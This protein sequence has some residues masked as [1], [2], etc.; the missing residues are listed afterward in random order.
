LQ[1]LKNFD[2]SGYKPGNFLKRSLWYFF[3]EIFFNTFIPF[4][5]FIK[6]KILKFFGAG[7]GKCVIIKPRVRIKYPWFLEIGDYSWI[8]EDVWI[9]NLDFVVIKENVCVSQ[10]AMILSGAHNYKSEK[11][12]LIT[13]KIIIESGAWICAKSVVLQGVK[14]K[15]N[16]ILSTSS[17]AVSDLDANFIY[18]GNPAIK[19]KER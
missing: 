18:K 7:V 8:G 15:S 10:G 3:S 5:G 12:D 9:D 13:K 16:S 4:P 1:N 6:L 19:Y 11:F 2:N 14:C 17:V